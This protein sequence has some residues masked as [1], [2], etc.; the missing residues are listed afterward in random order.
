MIEDDRGA[1]AGWEVLPFGFL[2]F[3]VGTLLLANAW[4]VVDAKMA[5]SA[6]AR[7]GARAFVHA[8]DE[9]AAHSR[10]G[11][12]VDDALRGHGR[13]PGEAHTLVEG[14]FARCGRVAVTVA[15]PVP[16]IGLP[17]VGG[18]GPV[19]TARSV[20]GELVDPLRSGVPGEADCVRG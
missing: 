10:A 12:A 9:S 15:I 1:V 8:A 7:E 19:L 14:D 18:L 2:V 3:V 20:H 5:A 17:W 6:A 13:S 4:G 11:G 16:T